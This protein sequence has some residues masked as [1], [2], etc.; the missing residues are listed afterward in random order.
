MRQH[1]YVY[2]GRVNY[3]LV[4]GGK[5]DKQITLEDNTFSDKVVGR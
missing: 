5:R 2:D 4:K 1:S 3:V